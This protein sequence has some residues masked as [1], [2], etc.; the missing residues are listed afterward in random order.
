MAQ[1]VIL[2]TI[3]PN[4]ETK[5]CV[6]YAES[7]KRVFS[8]MYFCAHVAQN[9]G[10]NFIFRIFEAIFL[11]GSPGFESRISHD[12]S[13]AKEVEDIGLTNQHCKRSKMCLFI[14][15]EEARRSVCLITPL[16][17]G[18]FQNLKYFKSNAM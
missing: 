6:E 1:L 2:P 15:K 14:P 8:S 12:F 17:K 10:E 13:H 11:L 4:T 5:N 7:K 16:K 18:S 3:N 9:S